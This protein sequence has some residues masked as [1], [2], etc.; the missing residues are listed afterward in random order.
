MGEPATRWLRS[1]F[2]QFPAVPLR[3]ALAHSVTAIAA[4]DVVKRHRAKASH[5]CEMDMR[6]W[7]EQA[8]T[9]L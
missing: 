9:T 1:P 2:E 3:L 4:S 8:E 7:L 5:M 6:F